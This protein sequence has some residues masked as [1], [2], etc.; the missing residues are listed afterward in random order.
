MRPSVAH[1]LRHLSP[2]GGGWRSEGRLGGGYSSNPDPTRLA[3]PR[4]PP[5]SG[6]GWSAQG[7]RNHSSTLRA[8]LTLALGLVLLSLTPAHAADPRNP[9][10]PCVQVKVPEISPAAVWAGAPFDDVGTKWQ[11]DAKIKDLVARLTARRTPLEDAQKL[12]AE[13]VT[14]S[15]DKKETGRLLFAG[16]FDTLNALRSD[17]INGIERYT[18][19][20][21]EFAERIRA[22]TLAL[23]ELQD[24]P[25]ADPKQVAEQAD[26]VQWETRIFEDR[27][28]TISYVCEVPV[29]IEQRLFALGRAIQQEME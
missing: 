11:D 1:E 9:D 15:T 7:R 29:L 13:F 26:R 27:R 8:C 6:G 17:V 4:H 28:R 22:E 24:K 23:R 16:V 18:R 10:W 5:L 21:R 25:N 12:A 2:A 19:R 20:Q 3:G 14:A